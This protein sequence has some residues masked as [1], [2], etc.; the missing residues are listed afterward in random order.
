LSVYPPPGP[1]SSD[2]VQLFYS[3]STRCVYGKLVLAVPCQTEI[4]NVSVITHLPSGK[5][6]QTDPCNVPPGQSLCYTDK[7]NDA[8]VQSA[9][10]ALRVFSTPPSWVG[11]T[12]WW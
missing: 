8:N 3:P 4:C 9:A 5:N 11:K 7:V 6:R 2:L 1:T 10:Q 12:Q